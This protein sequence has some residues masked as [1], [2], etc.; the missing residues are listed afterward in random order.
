MRALYWFREDLRLEDNPALT[1]LCVD[2]AEAVFVFVVPTSDRWSRSPE[3]MGEHRSRF[4][5]ESAVALDQDCDGLDQCDLDGDGFSSCTGDCDDTN[6]HSFPGAA[7]VDSET[8]CMKDEDQDGYGDSNA[9]EGVIS[10]TDCDDTL[11]VMTPVDL[12][13]DGLSGCDGDCDDT[14]AQISPAV[15]EICDGIDNNCDGIIDEGVTSLFF[16][17]TDGDGF[18]S[19]EQYIEGCEASEGYADNFL[20]CDDGDSSKYPANTEICDGKDNNCDGQQDEGIKN[21]PNAPPTPLASGVLPIFQPAPP[22]AAGV[23]SAPAP[24]LPGSASPNKRT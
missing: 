15:D 19:D 9:G 4:M 17:D 18:G 13:G 21:R 12:D 20:D 11:A 14:T 10:G 6:V 23:P 3:R 2:A 7:E 1:A 5:A 22:F 24:A 8:E 16:I